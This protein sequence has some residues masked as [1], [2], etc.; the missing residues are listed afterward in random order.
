M[1]RNRKRSYLCGSDKRKLKLKKENEKKSLQGSIAKFLSENGS[2]CSNADSSLNPSCSSVSKDVI[3]VVNEIIDTVSDNIKISETVCSKSNFDGKQSVVKVVTNSSDDNDCVDDFV[4]DP[5]L[6]ER[7]TDSMRDYFIQYPPQQNMDLI[8]MTE[9]VINNQKR[10]LTINHFFRNKCNEDR[11]KREWLVLSPSSGALFCWICKLFSK[12]TTALSSTGFTDWKHVSERLQDHENSHSHREAVCTM[13][14]RKEASARIDVAI[15]EQNYSENKYWFEVLRRVVSVIKFLSTRGMPFFGQNET[16]GSLSNGNFLGCMELLS[17]YDPFLAKHLEKHGNPGSGRTSYMSSTIITEFVELMAKKVSNTIITD[18]KNAKYFSI[19]L[20]S[21]PDLSHTDQLCFVIRYVSPDC[22]PVERFLTFLNIH[23]H[24]ALHIEETVV[25]FMED[26]SLSFEYCRGQGYDNASN[27][28]GKYNG[29]QAKIKAL[30][31]LAEFVPCSA[32]SLNLVIV[33]SVECNGKVFDFFIF[34]QELYN[35]F[36]AS[37]HRWKLLN[38]KLNQESVKGLTL[39]SRS[40][41][42]WCANAA[43]TKA[44]NQNYKIIIE[45]L[46]NLST[47]VAESPATRHEAKSLSAKLGRFET[48]IFTKCWDAI[49]QRVNCVSKMLQSP[50]VNLSEV[51]KFFNSLIDFVDFVRSNFEKYEQEAGLLVENKTY[52]QKRKVRPPQRLDDENGSNNVNFSAQE[53]F[54]ISCF[55]AICDTLIVQLRSRMSVY[56]GIAKRFS[57][58]FESEK[59]AAHKNAELLQSFYSSDLEVSFPDEYIQFLSIVDKESSVTDKLKK[60]KKGGIS[61]TFANVETALKLFLTL[62]V[63]NCSGERSFSLL[64]RI[65]S[66][67][68]TLMADSKLSSLAILSI[69]GDITKLLDYEDVISDFASKKFRRQII[70]T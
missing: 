64:K 12:S 55:Y 38:D 28:S 23:S 63:S 13:I 4:S 37:T 51:P 39:K 7:I 60:I 48:A 26:N 6:W 61:D 19:I 36:S 9:R 18:V 31:P 53:N 70:K 50:T 11:V 20:D 69:E 10:Q 32:H 34:L 49:L 14:L 24:N 42:R 56:E 41:T 52:T 65:K 27:M 3:D 35:F 57:C 54:K 46:N 30:N 2:G 66:P 16:I 67:L 44:L 8:K 5:Q 45:V 58:L 21:T 25:Q 15:T 43:A 47:N 17:E 68:R 1:K 40:A 29:L 33:K 59:K 62:P 22:E